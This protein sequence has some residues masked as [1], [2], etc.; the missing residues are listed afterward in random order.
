MRLSFVLT[1]VFLAGLL[2]AVPAP[3]ICTRRCRVVSDPVVVKKKVVVEDVIAAVFAPVVVAVPAYAATY[4]PAPVYAPGGAVT[5]RPAAVTAPGGDL[6]AILAEL[7]RLSGRLD[8][9]ERSLA[10]PG[11]M[12]PADGAKKPDPLT[13]PA[14]K[15]AGAHPGLTILSGRCASCHEAAV[16]AAKGGGLVLF[17]SGVYAGDDKATRRAISAVYAGRMPPKTSGGQL[18]DEEVAKVMEFFDRK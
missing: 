15:P 7:R 4:V 9:L 5:A 1:L 10:P 18:K 6:A 2:P 16:A 12:P 8:T 14:K 17:R 11:T 13:D 3:A